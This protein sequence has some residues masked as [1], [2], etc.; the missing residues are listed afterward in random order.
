M[1]EVMGEACNPASHKLA[2]KHCYHCP[3]TVRCSSTH[4]GSRLQMSLRVLC[5]RTSKASENPEM[6]WRPSVSN[7]MR[8]NIVG[9]A[10]FARTG[11]QEWLATRF[12]GSLWLGTFL[13]LFYFYFYSTF[14]TSGLPGWAAALSIT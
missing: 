7:K 5:E 12:F 11:T 3:S 13:L 1:P 10:L 4:W 8:P 6:A 9:L 2:C 14:P